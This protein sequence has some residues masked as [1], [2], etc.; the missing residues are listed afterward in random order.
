MEIKID[1]KKLNKSLF[2]QI[3]EEQILPGHKK[4][5][6]VN[7]YGKWLL[8]SNFENE[9][10]KCRIFP[11]KDIDNGFAMY[12][13]RYLTYISENECKNLQQIFL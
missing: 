10:R 4:I 6:I 5:G 7:Y 9:Y 1:G 3:I 13:V 8:F 12:G 2:K 11:Q